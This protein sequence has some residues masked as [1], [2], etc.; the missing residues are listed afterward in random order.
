M[1]FRRSTWEEAG[2]LDERYRFYAQDLDFCARARAKGWKVRLVTAARVVHGGG[3]TVRRW[4][5]VA[6]LPH[7]PGLLWLDLLTWGRRY[8]G[9]AWGAAAW[10][11]MSMA[12][13]LR[14]GGRRI[15]ELFLRGVERQRS[16]SATAVYAAALRQLLVEREE[17]ARQG[18]AGVAR[19]DEP[20]SGVADGPRG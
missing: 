10:A 11:L 20:P 15:R 3:E 14:V 2:P 1:A 13:V 6:E 8:Y 17:V 5:D 18:V 12:A 19:L 9:R 7:D 16:K 4:R